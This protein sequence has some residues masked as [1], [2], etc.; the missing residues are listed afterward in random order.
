MLRHSLIL[1][2]VLVLTI[3]YS[4][5]PAKADY[6]YDWQTF[7]SLLYGLSPPRAHTSTPE[8]VTTPSYETTF[9]YEAL[10]PD[11]RSPQVEFA[12]REGLFSLFAESCERIQLPTLGAGYLS[13]R[14]T[15]DNK[16]LGWLLTPPG[17]TEFRLEFPTH[18]WALPDHY[19]PYGNIVLQAETQVESPGTYS[20]LDFALY[21]F[22]VSANAEARLKCVDDGCDN[23]IDLPSGN[24]LVLI[25]ESVAPYDDRLDYGF[26]RYVA[27][28]RYTTCRDDC[29]A[30]WVTAL[31]YA[32]PRGKD[33]RDYRAG[34]YSGG[35]TWV[36]PC[37]E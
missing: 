8:P 24:T 26:A 7:E 4:S 10:L 5:E 37:V 15:H 32:L 9:D 22:S 23:V 14:W 18:D 20:H 16:P 31:R 11:T 6:G 17:R 36:T 27:E 19:L 29:G 3:A 25:D 12:R 21:C 34:V 33:I 35:N 2:V 1:L 30:S 28:M 13:G